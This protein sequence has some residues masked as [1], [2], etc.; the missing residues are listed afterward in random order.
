MSDQ[1][2]SERGRLRSVH[3]TRFRLRIEAQ[4]SSPAKPNEPE[5]REIR[6]NPSAAA[7]RTNPSVAKSKRTRGI[8]ESKRTR[9]QLKTKRT[10]E[11]LFFNELVFQTRA[12][13]TSEPRPPSGWREALRG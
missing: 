4:A 12:K 6:T 2:R 10:Q 5:R 9:A 11:I 13:L 8:V 1:E 3:G 7:I